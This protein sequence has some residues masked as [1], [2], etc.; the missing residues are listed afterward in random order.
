MIH[1]FQIG[2]L[3]N[4]QEDIH[5]L[6]GGSK[7]SGI[8]PSA[9]FPAIF[10]FTGEQGHQHGYEDNWTA[11]VFHYTGEG[12][13]GDMQFT[14][15]NKAIRD[16]VKDG[17]GLFLFKHLGKSKSY[18]YIG[19]FVCESYEWKLIPDRN[20]ENRQGI[21]FHLVDANQHISSIPKIDYSKIAF[22][23][24]RSKAYDVTKSAENAS[25]KEGVRR[26][27]E[28]SAYVKAYVLARSK[29]MCECCG[30][31][32]PFLRTDGTP[33]LEPHHIRQLSDK[34]LDRPDWVAAITPNCHREI[35]HGK[36]GKEK[37][38]RLAVIIQKKERAA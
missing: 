34:G 28:R 15:G 23:H 36:N 11:N 10:L 17:K 3:Y 13:I 9:K 1:N 4:R 20:R 16:H 5:K 14:K 6:Y 18:Q 12:Q 33:Y 21:I 27:Y 35:H 8:A 32:A 19:E 26:F 25:Y 29:G 2:H 31:S 7:Q 24:L 22:D 38:E 30:V 37:N